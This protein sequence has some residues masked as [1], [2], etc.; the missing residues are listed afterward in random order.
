V[1]GIQLAHEHG[2]S[3]EGYILGGENLTFSEIWKVIAKLLGK[4]EPKRRIPL[5]L[6]KTISALSRF[7]TGKSV[8]PPEFFEMIAFDWNYSSAKAVREL[9]WIFTPFVE[10]IAETWS[11]Y[12]AQGW[13]SKA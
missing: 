3:G 7:F 9:G 5:V 13:K 2:R 6:L 4:D 8:F 12:Q 1:R 10:G 11:D